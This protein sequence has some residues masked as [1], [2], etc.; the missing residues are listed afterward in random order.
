MSFQ[1]VPLEPN[2]FAHLFNL[3][4]AELATRKACRQV[5]ASNPGT[6]C[7]ISMEDAEIGETVIL[8]N[9]AHQTADTPY[10]ANH[11]IFVRENAKRACLDE[12]EVP[13]VIR[14][15]VISLRYFD[16]DHMM[17]DADVV[18][19]DAVADQLLQAFDNG[20]IAYVHLHYAKPAVSLP[21]RSGWIDRLGYR[22][23]TLGWTAKTSTMSRGQDGFGIKTASGATTLG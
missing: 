18:D 17:I 6:P 13:Q 23:R 7:R 20:K 5:V 12:N 16:Q 11:A 9:H 22:C 15:R 19:G 1:I 2:D 21:R 14:S 4:D 3:T 10:Q 8:V